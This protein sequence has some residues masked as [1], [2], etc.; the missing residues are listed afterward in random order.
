MSFK[1]PIQE[2]FSPMVSLINMA[3][4]LNKIKRSIQFFADDHRIIV[5][6][7]NYADFAIEIIGPRVNSTSQF[8]KEQ[9]KNWA[10]RMNM[11][12]TPI[13]DSVTVEVVESGFDVA[14]T[15]GGSEPIIFD[16]NQQELL[17]YAMRYYVYSEKR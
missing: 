16:I 2:K 5:R 13:P 17:K 8:T 14:I 15:F 6:G 1:D 11:N 4:E 3:T 7:G 9:F 12:N 10:D